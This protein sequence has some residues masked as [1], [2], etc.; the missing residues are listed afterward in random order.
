M[1]AGIRQQAANA[2]APATFGS[3]VAAGSLILVMTVKQDWG[4]EPGAPTPSGTA[5]LGSLTKAFG[6]N[7]GGYGGSSLHWTVVTTGG[8]LTFTGSGGYALHLV[9]VEG[10][11]VADPIEDADGAT[12]TGTTPTSPALSTAAETMVLF[13]FGEYANGYPTVTPDTDYTVWTQTGNWISG[14]WNLAV[15]AGTPTPAFGLSASRDLNMISVAI[16]IAPP[17][18][19]LP[20]LMQHGLTT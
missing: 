5:V 11:D 6:A 8:T 20:I 16:N 9:E 10:A 19:L 4:G 13:W 7:N 14:G 1:A 18:A 12:H 3:N 17:S 15:P 2:G